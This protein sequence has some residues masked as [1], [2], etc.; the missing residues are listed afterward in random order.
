MLRKLNLLIES[1]TKVGIVGRTGAGKSTLFKML[2]GQESPDAGDVSY[3]DTV[4]LAYVDQSRDDLKDGE[5]YF[6]Y[7]IPVSGGLRG[8]C[9]SGI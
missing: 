1:G 2:T 9:I 7:V 8:D 4:Q 6:W 3:G 5:S